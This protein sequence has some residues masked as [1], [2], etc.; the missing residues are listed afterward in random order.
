[1]G[2]SNENRVYPSGRVPGSYLGLTDAE[3]NGL[4][5]EYIKNNK[6]IT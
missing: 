6:Y 5:K 4:L 3:K 2:C 1:V